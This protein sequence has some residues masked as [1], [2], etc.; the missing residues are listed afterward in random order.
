MRKILKARACGSKDL[1]SN[2][3]VSS[4]MEGKEPP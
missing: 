1:I 3:P 4:S 2:R